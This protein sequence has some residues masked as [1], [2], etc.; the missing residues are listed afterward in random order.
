MPYLT[1]E[2]W[3][4]LPHKGESIMEASWPVSDTA[5]TDQQARD[6]MQTLIALITKVRNIR[7]EVNVPVQSRIK[8]HLAT[9]DDR[10]QSLISQNVDHIKRLARVEEI[11]LATKLPPLEK[12]VRD[13][14]AGVE[15]AVPLEGLI[16]TEKESER[17]T[18]ELS[19]KENEARG[20]ASRLDNHSFR[21]RAPQEVVQQARDRHDE[22]IAEIEKLRAT[23][24]ALGR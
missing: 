14:V 6:D 7:S 20:L 21:E 5:H 18:K 23:L 12:P 13:I 1:E 22:L 10:V 3:Q 8:L 24:A 17:L 2:I 11:T 4:R 15:L 9:E 16:D 19:R